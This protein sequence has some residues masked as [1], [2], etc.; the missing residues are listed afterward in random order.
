MRTSLLLFVAAAMLAALLT[1][2]I[3]R[4]AVSIGAV[5]RPKGRRVN[6]RTIPRLG[7]V[8]VFVA[9]FVPFLAVFWTLTMRR[10]P[11]DARASAQPTRIAGSICTTGWPSSLPR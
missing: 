5:D 10:L 11:I 6:A 1:P 8:A 3:R 7:G 2:V 4:W 9:F